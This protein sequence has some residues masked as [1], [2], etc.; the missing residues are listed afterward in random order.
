MLPVTT[1]ATVMPA[2]MAKG[3]FQGGIT[4]ANSQR[5]ID[6]LIALAGILDGRGCGGQAQRFLARA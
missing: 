6:Q 1:E 2:M 3:K 5:N 4:R